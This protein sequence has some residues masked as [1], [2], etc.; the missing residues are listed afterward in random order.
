MVEATEVIR[1]VVMGWF[2]ERH[3]R[4]AEIEG[5]GEAVQHLFRALASR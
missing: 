4:G 1:S 5:S 2:F 3:F